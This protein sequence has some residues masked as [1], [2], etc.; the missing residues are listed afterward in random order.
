MNNEIKEIQKQDWA[1][2]Q[3]SDAFLYAQAER[4]PRNEKTTSIF[5]KDL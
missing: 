2:S 1:E 4:G 5:L 3:T